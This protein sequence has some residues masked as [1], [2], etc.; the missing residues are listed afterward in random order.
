MS[1]RYEGESVMNITAMAMKDYPQ[2]SAMKAKKPCIKMDPWRTSKLGRTEWGR[3][4][5]ILTISE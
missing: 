1:S 4:I 5:M 2:K 3:I